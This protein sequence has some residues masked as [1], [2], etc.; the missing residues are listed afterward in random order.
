M[1]RTPA[2]HTRTFTK[3]I[4]ALQSQ[5]VRTRTNTG[6]SKEKSKQTKE[7]SLPAAACQWSAGDKVV[8]RWP[9]GVWRQATIV[10]VDMSTGQA[11]LL[12][13]GI[14]EALVSLL[15][16]R[17]QS[18][19]VEVLNLIDQGLVRDNIVRQKGDGA[20]YEKKGVVPAV[21]GEG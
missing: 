18:L 1:F 3:A 12:S 15:N 7:A 9:D 14:E 11:R 5:L 10:N 6:G 13:E 4:S 21:V 2:I 19:P 16:M 17:P 20:C 8:A